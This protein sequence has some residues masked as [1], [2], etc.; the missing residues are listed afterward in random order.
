MSATRAAEDLAERD[1]L[2]ALVG[3]RA[4]GD[5]RQ[6]ALDRLVGRELGDA[7]D[8]DELVHLLLDLLERVL[9]AV[10]A[11]RQPRDVGPLG[12]PDREADW[13]L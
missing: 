10:D 8:V 5:Q 9:G 12:R 4:D 13:M 6:L 7:Q 2:G 3:R 1:Q 11:Q